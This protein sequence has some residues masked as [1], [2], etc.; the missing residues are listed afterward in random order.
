[1]SHIRIQLICLAILVILNFFEKK[2]L[3]SK[4]YLIFENESM[5]FGDFIF[6]NS[7]SIIQVELIS[8]FGPELSHLLAAAG[9]KDIEEVEKLKG[10]GEKRVKK[11]KNLS[12]YR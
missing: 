1:M 12:I 10:F 7:N 3:E 11:L 6:L 9:I 5:N 8:G 4:N 2:N